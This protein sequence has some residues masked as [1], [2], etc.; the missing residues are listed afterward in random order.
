[1]DAEDDHTDEDKDEY[2][3]DD[4]TDDDEDK[5]VEDDHKDVD[6]DEVRMSKMVI[7]IR[8]RTR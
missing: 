5:D 6:E 2:A 8:T 4:H 3:K 7:K 1:M